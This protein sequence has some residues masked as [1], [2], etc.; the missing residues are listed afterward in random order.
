MEAELLIL[1]E[2][3]L[4]VGCVFTLGPVHLAMTSIAYHPVGLPPPLGKKETREL[5]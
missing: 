1:C 4:H 3:E 2:R 5:L